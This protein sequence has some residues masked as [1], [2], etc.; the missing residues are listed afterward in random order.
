M[1]AITMIRKLLSAVVGVLATP[2]KLGRKLKH[3]HRK[4]T[5]N[6]RHSKPVKLRVYND[7]SFLISVYWINYEGT[8]Q[9]FGTVRPGKV[10]VL[11]TFSTHPWRFKPS[12]GASKPVWTYAGR[13]AVLRLR[14]GGKLQVKQLATAEQQRQQDNDDCSWVK[15]EWGQYRQRGCVVGMP[16][17]VGIMWLACGARLSPAVSAV[18]QA[19][20]VY[21][22]MGRTH[23]AD[24]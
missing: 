24:A 15:P 6:K 22:C 14:P 18:R 17:M 8:L 12:D 3:R 5:W 1:P 20:A 4:S 21:L 11:N 10:H 13:S 2:I 16:I 7:C 19:C 23:A 9:Q